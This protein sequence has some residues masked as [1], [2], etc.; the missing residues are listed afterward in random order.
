MTLGCR[1]LPSHAYVN[2]EVCRFEAQ[3]AATHTPEEHERAVPQGFRHL[4]LTT[5]RLR[6]Y[7]Y[8]PGA[9]QKTHACAF[10]KTTARPR[11]IACRAMLDTL[12]RDML[13]LSW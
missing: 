8:L 12:T 5:V 7:R 1:E 13:H 11:Y 3:G 4:S 6:A 10:F 2:I 9:F